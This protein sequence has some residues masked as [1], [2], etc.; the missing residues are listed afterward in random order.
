MDIVINNEN[1]PFTSLYCFEQL[2]MDSSHVSLCSVNINS[3]RKY[4]E[5]DNFVNENFRFNFSSKELNNEI[6][7]ESNHEENARRIRIGEKY[8]ADLS[9]IN[10][11]M[12]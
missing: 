10:S 2:G 12:Q 11:G 8:Q 1:S 7:S 9:C 6:Q 4:C 5:F 3:I